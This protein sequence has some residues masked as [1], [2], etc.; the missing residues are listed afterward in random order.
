M[1]KSN[2]DDL[3]FYLDDLL[4]LQQNYS[5]IKEESLKVK[6]KKIKLKKH[7]K[8][9][10]K[11]FYYGLN[12][13]KIYPIMYKG[14]LLKKIPF[15]YKPKN[16]IEIV[17]SI[18]IEKICNVSFSKFEPNIM[19]KKHKDMSPYTYRS[20]LGLIVPKDSGFE[21]EGENYKV[22]ESE[23]NLFSTENYHKAWNISKTDRHILIID[24]FRPE[25]DRSVFE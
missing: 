10:K 16:T 12:S 19:S 8:Q 9:Y 20:H 21:L 6:H 13:W 2:L 11:N 14:K 17:K 22:E 15:T 1:I 25:Y 18:G 24:F 23:I 4:F 5:V 7:I 3:N